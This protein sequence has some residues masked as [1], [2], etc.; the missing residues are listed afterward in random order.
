MWTHLTQS[1]DLESI[2]N[3][4]CPGR[5]IPKMPQ[6]SPSGIGHKELT[7]L[8]RPH[9]LVKF[10]HPYLLIILS[11]LAITTAFGEADV[12]ATKHIT[13]PKNL[14]IFSHRFRLFFRHTFCRLVF[15]KFNTFRLITAKTNLSETINSKIL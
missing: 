13:F 4:D 1:L 3:T 11:L 7:P 14:E 10:A 9:S 2:A 12:T 6:A 8:L 15:S 5:L